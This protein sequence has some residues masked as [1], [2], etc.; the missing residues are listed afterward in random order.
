MLHL[1]PIQGVPNHIYANTIGIWKHRAWERKVGTGAEIGIVYKPRTDFEDATLLYPTRYTYTRTR[2]AD[3]TID[4]HLLSSDGQILQS[5]I[6]LP[7][8]DAKYIIKGGRRF[9]YRKLISVVFS[10]YLQRGLHMC[11]SPRPFLPISC[12]HFAY[13]HTPFLVPSHTKFLHSAYRHFS[14]R[15]PPFY[16]RI[17]HTPTVKNCLH[18]KRKLVMR[19]ATGTTL[20]TRHTFTEELNTCVG[21]QLLCG[22]ASSISVYGYILLLSQKKEI[23]LRCCE[24][25]H[26]I[27][28]NYTPLSSVTIDTSHILRV[29][30]RRRVS[31]F[32]H[33]GNACTHPSIYNVPSRSSTVIRPP[34]M[35]IATANSGKG[36]GNGNGN[37]SGRNVSRQS[38]PR[39][40]SKSKS[41]SRSNAESQGAE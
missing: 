37:G 34:P 14:P 27:T 10:V 41:K 25:S 24:G 1:S 3:Q 4:R 29:G 22:L 9:M 40:K 6:L 36:N 38:K 12:P 19:S 8:T 15:V 18:C 13:L 30:V 5:N 39:S 16:L 20:H 28:R 26:Q 2:K 23:H 35:A 31:A 32:V 21:V 11:V 7:W 17:S 33:V